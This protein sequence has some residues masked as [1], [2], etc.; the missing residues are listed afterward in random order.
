[1]SEDLILSLHSLGQ[2]RIPPENPTTQ[3]L[4]VYLGDLMSLET[5]MTVA[6]RF[7]I[8]NTLLEMEM[9][10]GE[11]YL[12]C[13]KHFG[14]RAKQ[15][16]EFAAIARSWVWNQNVGWA[17]SYYKE[18]VSLDKQDKQDLVKLYK[19][20]RLK[21]IQQGKE[22]LSARND[23]E[24]EK[25]SFRD[26]NPHVGILGQTGVNVIVAELKPLSPALP[27][28][29]MDKKDD[30]VEGFFA[31][32]SE[33][34]E[35]SFMQIQVVSA[36]SLPPNADSPIPPYLRQTPPEGLTDNG[37]QVIGAMCAL[38]TDDPDVVFIRC[39]VPK[40]MTVRAGELLTVAVVKCQM[41]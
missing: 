4:A 1:V 10:H 24:E 38:E 23:P 28:P 36:A 26:Q 16:L 19:Q 27:P 6:I 14:K 18:L 29:A 12:F 37:R 33:Q 30:F 15:M 5:Q 35:H 11:K 32:P 34:E 31:T 20:G 40:G 25:T 22:L 9:E 7:E 8:G 17:W 2:T 41:P 21:S 13:E 3:Q 39:E